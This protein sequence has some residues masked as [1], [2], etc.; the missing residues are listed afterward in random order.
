M[1]APLLPPAETE[2]P[3]DPPMTDRARKRWAVGML[4]VWFGAVLMGA[5]AVA[6][7]GGLWA[8]A[9]PVWSVTR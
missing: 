6:M 9:C 2:Q 3:D 1:T 5:H 4:L 8:S 7:H